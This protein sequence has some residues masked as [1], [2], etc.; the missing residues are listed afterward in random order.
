MMK[1]LILLLLICFNIA[2]GQEKVN[3]ISSHLES[4][5]LKGKEY[6]TV[7]GTVLYD[8]ISGKLITH[9]DKP[10][11]QIT[12]TNNNGEYIQY[13]YSNNSV[14]QRMNPE[15]SSKKSIFYYFLNGKQKDLDLK[16]NGY[17][18]SNSKIENGMNITTWVPS[19]SVN[20]ASSKIELVHEHNVPIFMGIYNKKNKLSLK[21][22][23]DD[24]VLV[25]GVKW[26]QQITE[27]EFESPKDSII[28]TRKYTNFK[29]NKQADAR[30]Q[31]FK[32]P[33]NAKPISYK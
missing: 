4:R 12:I 18:L 10:L 7:K 17:K 27:I 28:T 16:E 26:P 33:S 3:L 22:F 11:E 15:L 21:V 19:N 9:F 8:A 24:Y 23:Y 5:T 2:F 29:V 1:K 13:F 6:I 30:Y 31:N 32:V 25:N 20:V 14:S